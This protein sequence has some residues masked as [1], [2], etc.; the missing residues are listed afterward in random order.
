MV[1]GQQVFVK[2]YLGHDFPHYTMEVR[3]LDALR[4]LDSPVFYVD[5]LGHCPRN[6][7]VVFPI[8]DEDLAS[9]S[10]RCKLT[11]ADIHGL[12]DLIWIETQAMQHLT[13]VALVLR[14]SEPFHFLKLL[15][16]DP[17][18][19]HLPFPRALARY[20]SNPILFRYDP[21][22]DNFMLQ[23]HALYSIDFSMLRMMHPLF[24][25][26]FVLHD[27]IERPRPNLTPEPIQEAMEAYLMTY[28]QQL[29][30]E[31]TISRLLL[32][33]RAEALAHE[34]DGHRRRG[35]HVQAR[36]KCERLD[37]VLKYF[38]DTR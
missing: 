30:S 14:A 16:R 23:N 31:S 24:P 33:C 28:R 7:T 29:L 26:A 4:E 18:F 3:T 17:S 36:H 11:T 8:L 35:N 27:L 13:S 34:V 1:E 25:Y 5:Y 19:A 38:H 12:C 20:E 21:Q 2:Q 6:R 37:N 9:Y 15:A 22:M 10:R 32:L